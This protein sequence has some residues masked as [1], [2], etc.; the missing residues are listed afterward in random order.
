MI[1]P[2][3]KNGV[4]ID[5][6]WVQQQISEYTEKSEQKDLLLNFCKSFQT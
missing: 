6:E 2:R 1:T 5:K 4:Y 3:S